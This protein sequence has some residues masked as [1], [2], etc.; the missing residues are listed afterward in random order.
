MTATQKRPRGRPAKNRMPDPIQASAEDIARVLLR[1]PPKK[2]DEWDYL[3]PQRRK[4][5]HF[6]M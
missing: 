3:K 1:T 5:G 6:G 4:N 2:R